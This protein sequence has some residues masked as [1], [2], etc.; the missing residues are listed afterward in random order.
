MKVLYFAWLRTRIG[1][2]AEDVSP[3]PEVRSVGDLIS[4]LAQQSPAH[5]EALG[6]PELIRAAINQEFAG[7]DSLIA[8][9]DEIALFPPVTG[10]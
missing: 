10:G 2:D 4:W 3:P 9:T 7:T 6:R 5:A 1:T 8:A